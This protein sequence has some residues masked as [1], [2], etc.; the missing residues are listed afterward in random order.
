MSYTIIKSD[1]STLTQLV[2]G[3]INQTA[4]DLTLVGKNSS[5]Y[6]QYINDNFVWLLENFAG[7]SQPNHPITGQL[8][9][10]T[11]ENRLKVYDG[12]SFKVSGGTIVSSTVPSGIS[13]GDI[14]IDSSRQQLYFNDGFS[15][16][17]AGPLYTADQGITGFSTEDIVDTLGV[18]HT[19]LML[20]VAQTLIGIFSKDTFIPASVIPGY[21]GTINTGFNVGTYNGIK[22]HVPVTKADYLIAADGSERSASNFLST[23]DNSATT[24]TI[25]IQ[26]PVPLILGQGASTEINATTS[27][28]QIKSNTANQNFG[29][30]L[31]SGIGLRSAFFINAA[32]QKTGIFTDSP[33]ATLDVNG[34]TIIRG[35]LSVLGNLT[36]ISTTNVEISD[37][38]ITL[39]AT[40]SPSNTTADGGGISVA[41]GLDGDKTFAW[42]ATGENWESSENISLDLGKSYKINN[43]EVL[44]QNSLGAG[45]NFAPGLQSVGNLV[46]LTVSNLS[47]GGSGLESTI[48]YTG[49]NVSGNIYLSPKGGGTVDLG[50]NRISNLDT[51][52]DYYDGANKHYVD[53]TVR[54]APLGLY[55]AIPIGYTNA[56][57]AANY[58][59]K[60]YPPGDHEENTIARI[61]VNEG[62]ADTVRQFIL[63]A[64]TWSF[65]TNL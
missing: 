62:G 59:T 61:I 3:N 15:T 27:I 11:T 21:T 65:V 34:D 57:I 17:L 53:A 7:V 6:G 1:G 49:G 38:L 45:I 32:T 9:F 56:Q 24:G 39:G 16:K 30:T 25:S 37:K 33:Q 28:F 31:S 64:G 4:T 35:D 19:V 41:G 52:V 8:W 60:V 2:D 58:I 36:T 10:D 5:G 40:A 13:A 42:T 51:P 50:I 23:L 63:L 18:G 48:A 29:V 20:Y 12:T 46:G 55:V 54:G 47:F 14:W 22:L 44:S 26:N 43:I